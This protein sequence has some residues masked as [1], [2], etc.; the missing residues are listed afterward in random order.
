MNPSDVFI[1]TLGGF[2]TTIT[3]A[4]LAWHKRSWSE[5]VIAGG[6]LTICAWLLNRMAPPIGAIALAFVV[7]VCVAGTLASVWRTRCERR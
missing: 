7:A 1:F 2:F 5:I 4:A 6:T 3:C